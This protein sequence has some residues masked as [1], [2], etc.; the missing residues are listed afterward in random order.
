MATLPF[1]CL[2]YFR[3]EMF[4]PSGIFFPEQHELPQMD[5]NSRIFC[6]W[7]NINITVSKRILYSPPF[8]DTPKFTFHAAFLAFFPFC[9]Q[10]NIN[11]PFIFCPFLLIPSYFPL[12]PFSLFVFFPQTTSTDIS[13]CPGGKYSNEHEHEHE[14]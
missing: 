8:F 2:I 6:F 11:F 13:P 1:F 9:I 3:L 4:S 12:F 7:A 10:F 5:K 14:H